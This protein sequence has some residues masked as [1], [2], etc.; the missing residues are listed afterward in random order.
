M[1]V[2]TGDR[3]SEGLWEI[4]GQKPSFERRVRAALE[5]VKR[6]D[7]IRLIATMSA[8][9]Y[10]N[11]ILK[12]ELGPSVSLR[13]QLAAAVL[14]FISRGPRHPQANVCDSTHCAWFV[15]DG[16]VP[17]WLRPDSALNEKETA[18]DLADSEWTQAIA[19]V[20]DQPRGPDLWTADCGGNPVSSHFVWGGGDR[21]VVSCPRHPRGRG[22]AW[23]REWPITE[24]AAAFGVAPLA[25]DVTTVGGQWMLRVTIASPTSPSGPSNTVALGYDEAHR[26]LAQPMGWDALPAPASR[27]SRTAG[28]FTAEGVG[29]GHRAGLCLRP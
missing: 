9:D 3:F 12:A 6:D 4:Q 20:R 8:R 25:M 15:G 24:L 28:G 26:R 2:A 14:R 7:G 11:G 22:R 5:V 21:R 13:T 1:T 27:V 16:P 10:A 18:A 23:R 17:R 29:F 19:I